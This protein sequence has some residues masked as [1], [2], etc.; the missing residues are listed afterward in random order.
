MSLQNMEEKTITMPVTKL[1]YSS[2]TQ[3]LRNPLIFKMKHILGV[4]DTKMSPSGMIG[5]AGHE[6]LKLYYGGN[7]EVSVSANPIE[8]RGEAMDFGLQYLAAQN[9]AFIEYGKTGSRE[10]M[11]KEY[12]QAMQF[13][14]AEEPHYHKVLYV[15]DKFTVAEPRTI[16]DELLP[17]PIT[18]AAD[19]VNQFSDNEEDVEIIDTKFVTSFTNY[20]TEDYVKIVQAMFMYH[21][22]DGATGKKAKRMVFR[23]IK[24]TVN[25]D[26][27]PQVRDW[28]IPFD[29]EPYFIIFYNLF[30]DVVK[31]LSNDPVFLPNLSDM[32]DGEQAGLIYAQGLINADMSDVEVLH[33]VREVAFTSKKFVASRL[34]VAENKNLLPEEKIKV[35]LAEFGIPVV[36]VEPVV[37]SS[38]TQYRFKVSAGVRMS[39]ILKHK[40]DIALAVEA[41]GDITIL[42]PIPGTSLIGIEV[43]NKT[44]TNVELGETHFAPGTLMLPIGLTVQGDMVQLPLNEMP[45]L[46]IAGT[47][48]SGK[49]VA[50]NSFITALAQQLPQ[51]KLELVLIDPKRVELSGFAKLPHVAGN[52]VLYKYAD[53]TRK[54]MSLTDEMER[55]YELLEKKGVRDI[56]EYNKKART[57]KLKYIVVVIDE[58]ADFMLTADIEAQAYK[59][60]VYSSKSKEW[61]IKEAA[62]QGLISEHTAKNMPN[63]FSKTELIEA[64][65][66]FAAQDEMNRADANVEL[67]IVRLAQM[68][69]AIGIHLIIATQRPSVDVIT[70][71]IKANFPTRIALTTASPTDSTIILGQPG[72]EKL[73]GKGDMF[74]MSPALK[75]LQRV[76][77]FKV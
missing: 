25:Q 6:A 28:V 18:G 17:L 47:T 50:I 63:S 14:F 37:G 74:V 54:L 8:A 73:S 21:L 53:V 49:S 72:A 59:K 76:Q 52:K 32:F 65:E 2:L 30:R 5:R 7:K 75:G 77:G 11:M 48:G 45:H 46:L 19:V 69:R 16:Y 42:A 26:G 41:K 71:L 51:E 62:A 1:S 43:E 12:A 34:D 13:Y 60:P 55:R 10:K 22:I 56:T 67:L 58:F 38:V 40:A 44:R 70:G 23:E 27:S 15:E 3:L 24:R 68:A 57:N 4:Y 35:R 36:P 33:K 39:T 29:H 64:L 31:F 9:D 66:T 20:D 61:L